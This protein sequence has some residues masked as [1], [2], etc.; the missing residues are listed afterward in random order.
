[1][2]ALLEVLDEICLY[3]AAVFSCIMM[4]GVLV[5]IKLL[6]SKNFGHFKFSC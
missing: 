2:R 5:V 1:M 6:D 3:P 4:S